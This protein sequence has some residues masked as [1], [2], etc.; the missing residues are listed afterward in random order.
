LLAQ[1]A[2]AVAGA[3]GMKSFAARFAT[4]SGKQLARALASAALAANCRNVTLDVPQLVE[5]ARA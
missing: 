4:L 2:L 3:I 1:A 5:L